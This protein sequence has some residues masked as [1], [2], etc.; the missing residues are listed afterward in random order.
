[1]SFFVPV[2][3]Q[4][5]DGPMGG[6]AAPGGM[7]EDGDVVLYQPFHSEILLWDLRGWRDVRFRAELSGWFWSN[8]TDPLE[9]RGLPEIS[10]RGKVLSLALISDERSLR[11]AVACFGVEMGARKIRK[12][13]A[14]VRLKAA[15]KYLD[16]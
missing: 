1:M 16:A 15:D 2:S 4:T 5:P 13:M 11:Q 8:A 14:A 7:F 9:V 6:Y 10:R 3:I 12:R